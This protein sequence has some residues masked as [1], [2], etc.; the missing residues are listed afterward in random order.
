MVPVALPGHDGRMH[1]PLYTDLRALV[2]K[3][4]DDLSEHLQRGCY[5]LL[6]HSMGGWLAFEMARLA[7]RRAWPM[8]RLLVVAASRPPDEHLP[9]VKI[10]ELP[11]QE[12]ASVIEARYGGMPAVIR[13]N[14]E[15]LGMVV[16]AIRA[17]FQMLESYECR[18]EPPLDVPLLV[19]GGNA[20]RAVSAGDLAGWQRHTTR[21][22]SIR[23]F[24]GGHFF[25]YAKPE[26]SSG[27]HDEMNPALR[28]VVSKLQAIEC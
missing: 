8:P 20:D 22:A 13:D 10:Y 25:L 3:L 11:D 16:P 15:V 2:E 1:E 14:P 26:Q 6:G 5:A 18:D 7:R 9:Q 19:L 24:E 21:D 28:A 27:A 4:A 12:L 17:D 23:M